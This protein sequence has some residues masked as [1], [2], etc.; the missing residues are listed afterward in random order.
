MTVMSDWSL[1][2][3]L[4]WVENKGGSY[5]IKIITNSLTSMWVLFDVCRGNWIELRLWGPREVVTTTSNHSKASYHSMLSLF[6]LQI[7]LTWNLSLTT[8]IHS[9]PLCG[10]DFLSR[11]MHLNPSTETQRRPSRINQG[12]KRCNKCLFLSVCPRLQNF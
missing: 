10:S 2:V 4:I 8:L 11:E 9:S 12:M 7:S 6:P 5:I 3:R 1:W